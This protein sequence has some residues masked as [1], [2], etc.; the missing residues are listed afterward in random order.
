[1]AARSPAFRLSISLSLVLLVHRLLYRFF[2]RL[3]ANLRTEEA[4]PFRQR[5]RRISKALTS[6]YTPAIGASF[7]G[8]F[9]GVAPK[10]QFRAT[11]AIY[12]VTRSL[13]FVYNALCEK[14]WFKNKPRWF[15]S[16]LLMPLSCAQFFYAF[17][18]DRETIPKVWLDMW[19]EHFAD[20]G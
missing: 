9:L 14:G 2:S 20:S 16:W 12:A 6:K 5:N 1:M 11:A 19:D 17:M 10:A 3:R 13:E 7:A 15:G 8:L 4:R 18:F